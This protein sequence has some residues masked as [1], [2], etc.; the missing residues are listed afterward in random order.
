MYCSFL[1]DSVI[2]FSFQFFLEIQVK[3][4]FGN[5]TEIRDFSTLLLA[6]L[7]KLEFASPQAVRFFIKTCNIAEKLI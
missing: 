7:E 4:I 5:I 1:E 3:T 6:S 2:L